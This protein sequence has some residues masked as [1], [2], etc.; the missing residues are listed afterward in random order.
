MKKRLVSV[1]VVLAFL[2]AGVSSSFAQGASPAVLPAAPAGQAAA[3]GAAS[4]GAAAAGGIT[5]GAIAAAGLAAITL[6]G[7]VATAASNSDSAGHG[8]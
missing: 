5:V 1:A 7:I 3:A 2:L 6:V 8:H 4:G